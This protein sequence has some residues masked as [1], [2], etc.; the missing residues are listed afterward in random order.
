MFMFIVPTNRKTFTLHILDI[1]SAI[2]ALEDSIGTRLLSEKQKYPCSV[3]TIVALAFIHLAHIQLEASF[4][5]TSWKTK[6]N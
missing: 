2:K 5:R 4:R 6:E 3:S 1:A